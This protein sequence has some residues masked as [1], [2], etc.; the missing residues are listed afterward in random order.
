[1]LLK[2]T[3]LESNKARTSFLSPFLS[4][5]EQLTRVSGSKL[6]CLSIKIYQN[7]MNFEVD[8]SMGV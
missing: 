4:S 6:E 7:K 2:V 3:Q 5:I 1:M 8:K